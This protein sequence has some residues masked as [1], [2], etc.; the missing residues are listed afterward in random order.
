[1]APEHSYRL[2]VVIPL[3]NEEKRIEATFQKVASYLNHRNIIWEIVLVDDESRDHTV[4]KVNQIMR[5]FDNARLL[6]LGAHQGK[7][8]AIREGM[9]NS[10][11]EY[12]L[13]MDA[14]S[15]TEIYDFEKFEPWIARNQ[16]V[17]IGTRKDPQARLLVRQPWMREFLGK[18]FT[19]LSNVLM[20]ARVTDYTCGFKCFSKNAARNI[21]ML[22]RLNDWSFDA[23]II[24]LVRKLNYSIVEVPV[25]WADFKGTKVRLGRDI[26][27]SLL[28]LLKIRFYNLLGF[29]GRGNKSTDPRGS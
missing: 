8:G 5:G 17:I 1:M 26:L 16:D 25:T 10:K 24:F 14:D 4:Q 27:V 6:I 22:Q 9:L 7:G 18:G 13:F 29:Y 19:F 28:G 15:S 2:S 11:G 23:E 21:F 12:I 20:S 3:F